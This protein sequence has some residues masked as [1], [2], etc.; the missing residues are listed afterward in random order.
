MNRRIALARTDE[1]IQNCYPVM[2]ELRPH[3]QPDEFLQRIKRQIA[4]VRK[5]QSGFSESLSRLASDPS[6]Y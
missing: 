6:G 4:R 2:A 3:V 1:E 5:D